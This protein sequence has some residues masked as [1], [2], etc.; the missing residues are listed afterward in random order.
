MDKIGAAPGVDY[1]GSTEESKEGRFRLLVVSAL[2]AC[3]LATIA[4]VITLQPQSPVNPTNF[5]K[6]TIGMTEN[7]VVEVFGD[8]SQVGDSYRFWA[9]EK[10]VATIYFDQDRL[11]SSTM[12][13]PNDQSFFAKLRRRLH[14]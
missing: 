7:E 5:E 10:W 1:P 8:S 13:G 9:G 2:L 11:V 3:L 12:F 6:I 4:V 14:F